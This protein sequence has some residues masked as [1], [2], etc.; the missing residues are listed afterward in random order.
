MTSRTRWPAALAA[1][2][3]F[4]I[5][6]TANAAEDPE[7][8]APEAAA[9][10]VAQ[11]WL[12]LVDAGAYGQSWDTAAGYLRNAISRDQWERS[13]DAYRRPLGGVVSRVLRSGTYMTALPGAPD[14][15]YVVLQ[16]GTSFENKRS[17][18][19]TV[20]PMLDQDGRWR[21]SGY[22]IN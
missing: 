9:E 13:M 18:V 3:I 14:G 4:L 2:G 15:H 21:V 22:Y 10:E 1:L 19:E 6:F 8:A 5:C 16:F 12:A 20:T 17:G 11:A 7:T